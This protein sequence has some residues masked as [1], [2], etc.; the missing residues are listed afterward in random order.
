MVLVPVGARECAE[1]EGNGRF[2]EYSARYIRY[3]CI[4]FLSFSE[5]AIIAVRPMH[6][7]SPR[8][9]RRNIYIRRRNNPRHRHDID[10]NDFYGLWS[11]EKVSRKEER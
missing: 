4:F 8:I 6:F 2:L 3:H 10:T 5:R 7:S 9:S 11:Y 1:E